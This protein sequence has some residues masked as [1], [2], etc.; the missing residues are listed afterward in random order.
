[1]GFN[2][3]MRAAT[4]TTTFACLAA[5]AVLSSC[6]GVS[7]DTERLNA[8]RVEAQTLMKSHQI[9]PPGAWESVPKE[10]WPATIAA[11][12]PTGVTVHTWGVD[13]T[14]KADFDGGYGYQVRRDKADLPMP[15]ACYPEVGQDI[16]SYR[17]C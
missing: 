2:A 14:T 12:H 6:N 3:L 10:Q 13:I 5:M 9:E 4:S 17:P 7:L 8:I 11:L 16:F 15:L 1:M